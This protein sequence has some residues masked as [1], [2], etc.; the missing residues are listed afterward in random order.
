M[1]KLI[2]ILFIL[3]TIISCESPK[4]N[5]SVIESSFLPSG[6]SV[7]IV[8]PNNYKPANNYPLVILLH[9]WS[10][11]Y[12]QWNSIIEL[13]EY[14]NAYNFIIACPDGFYDSWYLNN[15]SETRITI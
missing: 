13:Q 7:L 8:K 4:P 14:A 1:K 9:G 15:S 5:I 2:F 12:L 10:G 6:D 3:I 11:N